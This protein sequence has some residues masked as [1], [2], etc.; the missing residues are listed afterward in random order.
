M[1]KA[2]EELELPRERGSSD[3][4]KWGE[5]RRPQDTEDSRPMT[6]VSCQALHSGGTTRLVPRRAHFA[7]EESEV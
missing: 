1:E 6:A 3:W 4:S 5:G 7:D 2:E